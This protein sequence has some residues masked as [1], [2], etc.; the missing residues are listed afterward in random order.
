MEKKLVHFLILLA[1][2]Y[3]CMVTAQNRQMEKPEYDWAA[4]VQSVLKHHDITA[5]QQEIARQIT[6]EKADQPVSPFDIKKVL[7]GYKIKAMVSSNPES[8]L[9]LQGAVQKSV[10][11]IARVKSPAMAQGWQYLLL[12]GTDTGGN[13]EIFNPVTGQ[14]YSQHIHTFYY[15]WS[16]GNLVLAGQKDN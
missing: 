1:M 2:H 8:A 7:L 15:V 3:S 13:I 11:V 14:T 5:E 10:H 12:K 4:C 6:P 9:Q 16:W